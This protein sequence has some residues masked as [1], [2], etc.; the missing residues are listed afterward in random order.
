MI[1]ALIAGQRNPKALADL[2]NGRLAPK[3]AA[4][5]EALDGRFEPHH[6]ELARILLDQIDALTEPD[7]QLTTAS[8]S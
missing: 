3:R 2:A 4:L 6:G 1:E 7:R 5:A 8:P